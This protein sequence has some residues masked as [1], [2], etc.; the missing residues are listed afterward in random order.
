MFDNFVSL[1]SACPVA[2]S[3][4]KY[5]LRSWSGP[6][7][8]LI[9]MNL[10]WVLHYIENN[11]EDFLLYENIEEYN[12]L[13][14]FREIASDFMFVHEEQPIAKTYNLVKAKYQRR[15]DR[16]IEKTKKPTCFLRAVLGE[17]ED[18][19]IIENALYISQVIKKQNK[20]NEII[21]LVKE[22]IEIQ[23]IPFH[24]YSM[25]AEW[26]GEAGTFLEGGLMGHMSF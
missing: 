21:F 14:H 9:T 2:A 5:G 26:G 20:Y 25:S 6:F 16:F 13:K 15:I 19:I 8:W 3:M 11:F 24:S 22:G 10:G 17:N 23:N 1:G 7:D 12:E 4:A 18:D